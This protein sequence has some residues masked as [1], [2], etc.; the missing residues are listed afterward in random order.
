MKDFRQFLLVDDL[1]LGG[2]GLILG[3]GAGICPRGLKASKAGQVAGA[4]PAASD[5]T[6]L[7]MKYEI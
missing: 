4:G 6:V 1:W 5:H 3:V 2:S 7:N